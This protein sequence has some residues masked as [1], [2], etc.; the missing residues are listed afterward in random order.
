MTILYDIIDM[1]SKIYN[2]NVDYMNLDFNKDNFIV[3]NGSSVID[4]IVETKDS[5]IYTNKIN[6]IKPN[7]ESIE[8]KLVCDKLMKETYSDIADFIEEIC[9]TCSNIKN[10]CINCGVK[11]SFA[12][13]ILTTC[14]DDKC[15]YKLEELIIDDDVFEYIKKYPTTTKLLVDIASYAI[16]SLKCLDLFDPFP[17]YFLKSSIEI[18]R[19]TISKISMNTIDYSKYNNLKDFNRIKNEINRIRSFDFSKT[20]ETPSDKLIAQKY[21][22]DFYYLLRFIIKS[23]KLEIT[24]DKTCDSISIYKIKN[25]FVDEEA[26]KQKIA[27]NNNEKCYLF[28]GSSNDCWYSILRNGVKVLS[29]SQLQVN[30]AAYGSGIYTSNNYGVSYGYCKN[31][32]PIVGVYEV[33]G[34]QEKYKKV[35]GIYVLPSNDICILRYLIVGKY[36]NPKVPIQINE[37]F[38]KE[39]LADEVVN[40]IK[41][42]EKGKKKLMKELDIVKNSFS[43]TLVEN[44]ICKWNVSNNKATLEII[45]PELYPFEPPFVYI[46]T[47]KFTPDSKYISND[48]ALC[49]EYLTP[50]IWSPTISI[51]NLLVQIFSLII[52]PANKLND[53]E[54]NW[55]Y[56]KK[57]YEKIAIG[58][59][60]IN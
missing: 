31:T 18:N 43:V 49:L 24:L 50:A 21:G 59:G 28:H 19:G 39:I 60:W 35:Q 55:Y 17:P 45:F 16:D 44:N 15:K 53:E 8:T 2:V 41:M 33:V 13:D 52:E 37:L 51:E 56:A 34:N 42:S 47:P 7:N 3:N 10:Y 36:S 32:F 29:G 48:G 1:Y 4:F 23:C 58:N 22:N 26:F 9:N 12:S 46:K 25:N 20:L 30:G 40:K 27:M 6:K 57:S 38:E 11:L 5:I 14:G 54:N